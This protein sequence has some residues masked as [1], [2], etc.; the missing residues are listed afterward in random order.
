MKEK[1]YTALS[2]VVDGYIHGVYDFFS[3][4]TAVFKKQALEVKSRSYGGR[5]VLD[6]VA[7]FVQKTKQER[8]QLL[9]NVKNLFIETGRTLS[10]K[11]Y[12]DL[13]SKC[14]KPFICGIDA[15]SKTLRDEF[16]WTSSPETS[17]FILK[18][19][20]ISIIN[21]HI[22]TFKLMTSIHLDKALQWTALGTIFAGVSLLL[23][24]VAIL[25]SILVQR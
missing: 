2:K 22:D 10:E 23:S 17:L 7:V 9:E 1:I 12:N 25:V 8:D 24:V 18:E 15:F 16:E 6:L 20:T 5:E 19:S 4:Q 3:W 21:G 11:Q 14:T 13:K